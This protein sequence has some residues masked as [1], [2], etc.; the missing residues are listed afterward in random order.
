MELSNSVKG[1]LLLLTAG[2]SERVQVCR[3]IDVKV[4]DGDWPITRR[5]Q[6]PLTH[7]YMGCCLSKSMPLEDR[8]AAI[9]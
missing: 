9:T 3:S 7:V 5:L 4:G 2:L 1:D 8:S 6:S